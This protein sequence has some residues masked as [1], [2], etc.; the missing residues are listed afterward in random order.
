MTDTGFSMLVLNIWH[1]LSLM[2]MEIA[3]CCLK[4]K[5]N[6]EKLWYEWIFK[7][8]KQKWHTSMTFRAKDMHI[9]T[10]HQ[11]DLIFIQRISSNAIIPLK[12]NGW[13]PFSNEEVSCRMPCN[14]SQLGESYISS[15]Q[16]LQWWSCH[17]ESPTSIHIYISLQLSTSHLPQP[18]ASSKK[19]VYVQASINETILGN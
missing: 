19:G 18:Q 1:Y 7:K 9:A 4:L 6:Q 17:Q 13:L 8:I 11:K 12:S 2:P 5:I 15:K 14:E 16:C 3:N 10:P